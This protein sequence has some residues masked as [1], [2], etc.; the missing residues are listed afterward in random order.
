M[1][2]LLLEDLK[3]LSQNKLTTAVIDEFRRSPVLNI[4]GFDNT[5]K[6]QGG[7]T[8]FYTYN[9]VTDRPAGQGRAINTEYSATKAVTEDITVQLKIFGG[10]F[11]IDRALARVETGQVVDNVTFQAQQQIN[12]ATRLFNDWFVNGDAL[13]DPL[14][15][16]G[17]DKIASGGGAELDVAGIDL[18]T[19]AAIK[20]NWPDL[21]YAL[22]QQRK[23]MPDA[24]NAYFMNSDMF[25]VFQSI[26]DNNVQFQEVRDTMGN[27][28]IRWGN[29]SLIQMGDKS[30]LST[31]IIDTDDS[32]GTTTIYPV[33]LN[34]EG[35]HGI[36]P[37]GA[38]GFNMY[39]PDFTEPGAVKYGEVEMLAA[40]VAKTTRA[41]G[42]IRNI[43]IAA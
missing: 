21:L 41:V 9:R 39:M 36:T 43:K 38:S 2:L 17:I 26:A 4:L 14:Q 12:A 23:L 1:A 30:G 3:P 11:G 10:K 24:P 40:I 35:V 42:A 34:E 22:R 32:A 18:S 6:P 16:D 15:F 5:I 19:A 25:A 31:P 7:N 20:T 33:W 13:A 27:E 29:V 37:D 28:I 8:F